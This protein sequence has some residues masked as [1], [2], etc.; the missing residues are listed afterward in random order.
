MFCFGK[1]ANGNHLSLGGIPKVVE[2]SKP[3]HSEVVLGD[4]KRLLYASLE[5]M[6]I[7]YI[8]VIQHELVKETFI[9]FICLYIFFYFP[10][11]RG[12][13]IMLAQE[14]SFATDI[15]GDGEQQC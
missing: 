13:P 2:H 7:Q 14:A 4:K 11:H 12:L 5:K 3:R 10:T 6:C 15:V 9:E 1:Q 8:H